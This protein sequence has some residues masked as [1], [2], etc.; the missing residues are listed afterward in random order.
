MEDTL[1]SYNFLRH[2]RSKTEIS[3]IFALPVLFNVS[4]FFRAS[5]RKCLGYL[6]FHDRKR[7]HFHVNP[8]VMQETW[9]RFLGWEDPL[10]KGKV[11]TPVFWPGEF[12]GLYSP[13]GHKQ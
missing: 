13:W 12:H 6:T 11:P 3:K 10:E 1:L 4:V 9:V 8:P 7:I 2:L 5:K